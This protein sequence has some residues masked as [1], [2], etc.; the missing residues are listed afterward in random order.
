MKFEKTVCLILA[1]VFALTLSGCCCIPQLDSSFTGSVEPTESM[2]HIHTY[3]DATCTEPQMCYCGE[4]KG[5]ALGHNWIE[6]TCISPKT[7]K[8]CS[9][10]EG[11]T[12]DHEYVD[13]VCKYCY[14]NAKE[15]N[16]KYD[17]PYFI[18]S[19]DGKSI[20]AYSFDQ[21]G[22]LY[23]SG[24]YFIGEPMYDYEETITYNGKTYSSG[25]VGRP[26]DMYTIVGE[27]ICVYEFES[28][29]EFQLKLI[30]DDNGN[31]VVTYS[32]Y[33]DS[34]YGDVGTV[35]LKNLD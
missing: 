28:L 2:G 9:V 1:V 7:C 34:I 30:V 26:G 18:V 17:S 20:T 13:G 29:T 32:K 16:I 33:P 4:T 14:A 21:A 11:T 19:K 22:G 31:L 8:V 10:T 27:E 25:G 6:A 3:L 15:L 24:A 35:W 5:E 23:I 12:V